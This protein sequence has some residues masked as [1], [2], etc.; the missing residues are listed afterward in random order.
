MRFF[1]CLS[2]WKPLNFPDRGWIVFFKCGKIMELFF[3]TCFCLIHP[4]STSAPFETLVLCILDPLGGLPHSL[5]LL[6]DPGLS[7]PFHGS[8]WIISTDVSSSSLFFSSMVSNLL[9]IPSSVFFI[10]I[11][12]SFT[13][14]GSVWCFLSFIRW[15][16][17][18][19][20]P[21]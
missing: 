10:L 9:F 11:V 20:S 17:G 4:F 3:Q 12:A 18:R 15:D 13:S 7:V 1:P 6:A 14:W 2:A 16:Q 8:F 21:G 5:M 19:F